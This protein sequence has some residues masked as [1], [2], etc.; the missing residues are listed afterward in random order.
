MYF[1][2][3]IITTGDIKVQITRKTE[4]EVIAETKKYCVLLNLMANDKSTDVYI[5]LYEVEVLKEGTYM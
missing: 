1:C 3:L 2:V 5:P 4:R